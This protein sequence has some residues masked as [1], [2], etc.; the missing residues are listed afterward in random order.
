LRPVLT[1]VRFYCPRH[2]QGLCHWMPLG[3]PSP[4]HLVCPSMA[5][6]CL[7]PYIWSSLWTASAPYLKV[8]WS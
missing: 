2:P 3:L 4:D 1:I 6:L 8:D 5:E 7:R